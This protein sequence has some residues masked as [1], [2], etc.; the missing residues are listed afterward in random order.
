MHLEQQR[1]IKIFVAS[2]DMNPSALHGTGLDVHDLLKGKKETKIKVLHFALQIFD[3]LNHLIVQIYYN[4]FSYSHEGFPG[5][6]TTRKIQTASRVAQASLIKEIGC[7]KCTLYCMRLNL[8][9]LIAVFG[10][11]E[12]CSQGLSSHRPLGR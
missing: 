11:Q 8:I 10:I 2:L 3:F 7:P 5:K 9:L 12:P 1:L 4:L 6:Y